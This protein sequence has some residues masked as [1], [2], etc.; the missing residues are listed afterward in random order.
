MEKAMLE[1]LNAEYDGDM[2]VRYICFKSEEI[3]EDFREKMLIHNSING[4]LALNILHTG[5]E[6][7]FRYE[8]SDRKNLRDILSEKS[9]SEE[10]LIKILKEMEKI[11]INGR[12]FMFD[13][14]NYV[15]HPDAIFI[16]TD[17]HLEICYLPGYEKN[18]QEQL[19][20]LFG[21]FM[22][23]VDV[24]D[25]RSVYAVYSTYTALKDG[26]TTFGSLI[27]RLE[28]SKENM[29]LSGT[30]TEC[31]NRENIELK[32]GVSETDLKGLI[33]ENLNMISE[34]QKQQ[35]GQIILAAAFIIVMIYF[36]F[37]S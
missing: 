26:N 9:L 31:I 6:K 28:K 2:T 21:Y 32:K 37:A 3:F 35:L 11:F 7:V 16:N 10:L 20:D 36:I 8:I 1:N 15:I 12:N 30:N 19:C 18:I 4:Y 29:L 33:R 13:E 22:N 24:S 27:R 14:D 34:K 23:C 17:E 5:N 25:R